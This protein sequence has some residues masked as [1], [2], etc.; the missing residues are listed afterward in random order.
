MSVVTFII[1]VILNAQSELVPKVYHVIASQTMHTKL[2]KMGILC[3]IKFVCNFTL[4]CL[5]MTCITPERTVTFKFHILCSSI[6]MSSYFS[7]SGTIS[8]HYCYYY[9]NYYFFMFVSLHVR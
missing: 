2:F 6:S 3:S 9:Y 1:A 5:T 4:E 8:G 7:T